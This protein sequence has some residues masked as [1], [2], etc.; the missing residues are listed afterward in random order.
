MQSTHIED[1]EGSKLLIVKNIKPQMPDTTVIRVG[2][3]LLFP[4]Y[5]SVRLSDGKFKKKNNSI[6]KYNDLLVICN[7]H[8]PSISVDGDGGGRTNKCIIRN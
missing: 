3:V 6:L 4:I 5:V 2:F 7:S 8:F 1:Q